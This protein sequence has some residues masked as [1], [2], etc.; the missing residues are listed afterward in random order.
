MKGNT[1]RRFLT[2]VAGAAIASA[3]VASG[4]SALQV[5]PS[6]DPGATGSWPGRPYFASSEIVTRGAAGS[7]VVHG[8]CFGALSSDPSKPSLADGTLLGEYPYGGVTSQPTNGV[9]ASIPSWAG[10]SMGTDLGLNYTAGVP[11]VGATPADANFKATLHPGAS[12]GSPSV[13]Y[14]GNVEYLVYSDSY[15]TGPIDLDVTPINAN[16]SYDIRLSTAGLGVDTY[17]VRF[18]GCRDI[19]TSYAE[20]TRTYNVN[21]YQGTPITATVFT[22]VN[23]STNSPGATSYVPTSIR[24]ANDPAFPGTAG[25]VA[26][27]Y[28]TYKCSY[29]AGTASGRVLIRK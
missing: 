8:S 17:T 19:E 16:G 1:L 22:N 14:M 24:A 2:A 5:L 7:V 12:N 6:S 10:D 11:V 25:Q 3:V 26:L 9:V 23:L 15:S 29:S 4:A 18:L 27:G 21:Y 28:D 20:V 13:T